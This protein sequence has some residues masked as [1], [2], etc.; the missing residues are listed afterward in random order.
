MKKKKWAKRRPWCADWAREINAELSQ[1]LANERQ[2]IFSTDHAQYIDPN[3][4]NNEHNFTILRPY[5]YKP[6]FGT[7]DPNILRLDPWF[8]LLPWAGVPADSSFNYPT[9]EL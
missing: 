4:S 1:F 3:N 2:F 7:A 6:A 5:G 9:N 8:D